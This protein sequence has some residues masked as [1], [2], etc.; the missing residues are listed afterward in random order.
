M[1]AGAMIEGEDTGQ[2]SSTHAGSVSTGAMW[3]KWYETHGNPMEW[4]A[5]HDVLWSLIMPALQRA[6]SAA[7]EFLIV[8]VGC[9]SSDWGLE[10][11]EGLG[12]SGR[13]LLVD[14]VASLVEDLQSR[15]ATDQR[16]SCV[17]GDCRRLQALG[18]EDG[19]ASVVLDKGTLDALPEARE[20]EAMLRS[21]GRLLRRPSG[22]LV[23]VSFA[24]AARVMLLR[25]AAEELTLQLRL[26]IVTT[27]PEVRLLAFLSEAFNEPE[28]V[29]EV[30]LTKLDTLLYGCPLRGERFISFAH[31]ALPHDIV[32]EQEGLADRPNGGGEDATGLAVW[33]AAH[34][35]S[36]HLCANPELV[37]GCRIVE[38][39]AGPGLVGIVAAA[40]GAEEAVLSDLPSALPLLQANVARNHELCAG[41]T[42]VIELRWGSEVPP[43]LAEACDVVI[44]CEVVYQ[45][46]EET[47]AA[48][49][50]TMRRLLRGGGL[51]LIAYE[52][53]DG[54][55]ADMDFFDHVNEYFDVEVVS[56]AKYGYGVSCLADDQSRLLYVYRLLGGT[57]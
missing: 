16:I 48:L 27:G 32:V 3:D 19:A 50:D 47:A 5:G 9:G 44:G 8:D 2:G 26:R 11:L 30:T 17:I 18:L 46:D 33:P 6:A 52:F 15:H 39:G 54:M 28:V 10:V 49:V 14:S 24:T 25:R 43:D 35:L 42:R 13:L 55:L 36:A 57:S 40:L 45:H 34:A 53:R 4:H 41:R 31:A 20:R 37:R 12:G 1:V 29:D 23:S 38:L 56:L 21:I 7:K 22:V 51:C